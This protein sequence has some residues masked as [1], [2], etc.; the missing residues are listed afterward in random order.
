M[1]AMLSYGD[2]QQ[3]IGGIFENIHSMEVSLICVKFGHDG[4]LYAWL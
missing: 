1:D 2:H 4:S 3:V